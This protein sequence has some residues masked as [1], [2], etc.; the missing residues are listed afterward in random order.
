MTNHIELPGSFEPERKRL[1]EQVADYLRAAIVEGDLQPGAQ[2]PTE[3]EL[4]T[5]LGV[6][7]PTVNDAV[8]LLEQ[9]GLVRLKMGSGTFVSDGARSA[10]AEAMRRLFTF[11]ALDFRELMVF[12]EMLEPDFAALAAERATPDDIA[13]VGECCKEIEEAWYSGDGYVAADAGFHEALAHATGNELV[14]AVTS[15]IQGLLQTAMDAQFHL[16]QDETSEQGILSHRP[17]YE[18]I[19]ARDC[20]RARAAMEEH[21]RFSR[22][23]MQ[24]VAEHNSGSES[25]LVHDGN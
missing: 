20:G 22:L 14:M 5:Q 25:A 10:F 3:R 7:H 18:A 21:M 17:V 4:A 15:G 13:T 23:T 1:H 9:Q 16:G 2:L 19:L 6:S 11:R 8:R 24:R 12:R